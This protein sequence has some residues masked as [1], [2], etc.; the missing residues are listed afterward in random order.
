M[1]VQAGDPDS[2]SVKK[3]W[4]FFCAMQAM[5]S[6]GHKA[7]SIPT[8]RSAESQCNTYI[9][10][11]KFHTLCPDG[12]NICSMLHQQSEQHSVIHSSVEVHTVRKTASYSGSFLGLAELR[13]NW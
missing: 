10:S 5:W 3:R 8:S 7:I 13:Q 4:L 12:Q 2:V 11:A 6:E 1:Q 9:R